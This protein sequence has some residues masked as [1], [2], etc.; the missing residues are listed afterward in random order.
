[1]E[2]ISLAE[3]DGKLRALPFVLLDFA[4][5]GCA[6]CKKIAQALPAL[7][8]SLHPAQ[9][10]AFEVDI[11][12]DAALASRFFV[13]GVPALILFKEGKEIARFNSLPKADTIK[14]LLS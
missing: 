10:A 5:P 14:R 11:T 2:K 13:L 1:M 9:V 12:T 4:S 6:P 7:L 3:L 8:E